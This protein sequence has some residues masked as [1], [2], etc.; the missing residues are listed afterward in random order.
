MNHQAPEKS[1]KYRP[2]GELDV[3]SIFPTIQGE[4]PFSGH[5]AVFIRLA[6]CNLQCPLCDT[7]YTKGRKLQSVESIIDEVVAYQ[8]NGLVVITGGEPLRQ[9]ITT[10]CLCLLNKGYFVQIETNG[11]LPPPSARFLSLCSTDLSERHSVFIVCSPKTGRINPLLSP[12]VAA[13]KYVLAD[14][15]ASPG[16]GLPIQVL[17]HS[18]GGRVARP[19]GDHIRRQIPIYMQPADVKDE[20]ANHWNIEAVKRSCLAHGYIFQL[21]LHKLIGVE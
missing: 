11:T 15:E 1:I 2:T 21:Q 8:L 17:D 16:D 3:H 19:S 12:A 4:G 13:L 14:G 5:R 20:E 10:L 9:D 6:G 18:T 7:Q